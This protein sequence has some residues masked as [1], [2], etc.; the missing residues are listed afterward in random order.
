MKRN[1]KKMSQTSNI[2][3]ENSKNGGLEDGI[4]PHFTTPSIKNKLRVQIL[5]NYLNYN[6]FLEQSELS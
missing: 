3:S 1:D 4:F 2:A 5:S 6:V